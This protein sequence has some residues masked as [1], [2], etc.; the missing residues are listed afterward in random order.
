[1]PQAKT[2]LPDV[3][4]ATRAYETWLG[5]R[6]PLVAKDLARKHDLMR[7]SPFVFLRATFYRWMQCWPLVCEQAA[8]APAILSI[9]D[10][11]LQNFGT[12][13][14]AEA[15]LNWGVNDWDEAA[16]LPYTQDLVRLAVSAVLAG[17]DAGPTLSVKIIAESI[18][19]GYAEGLLG[20]GSP[21][22]LAERHR[23][24]REQALGSVVDAEAFWEELTGAERTTRGA[25]LT[26]LRSQLPRGTRVLQCVHRV[27]GAGSL[28]RPRF[29]LIG[30]WGG[31][32]VAR[33]AKRTAPSGAIWAQGGPKAQRG[34][35]LLRHAVRVPDPLL[36]INTRWVVRRLAPD[37][38]KIELS[39]FRHVKDQRKLLQL[40]GRETAN[41][42]VRSRG[43]VIRHLRGAPQEWLEEAT[44]AM[45]P[46][47]VKDWK[48]WQRDGFR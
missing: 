38:K 48:D 42:H 16:M 29:V 10:L 25:P 30:A 13:R 23:A 32:F 1:M 37:C 14:D 22:V 9:G 39:G 11:H 31:A 12:W 2:R 20:G 15:R 44:K 17:G 47:V 27:A 35:E 5:R 46:V 19:D 43:R 6:M 24:L 36:R 41:V 21:V 8:A 34:A 3:V 40:M 4:D 28:G 26:L 45:V 7:E 18:L 33:E